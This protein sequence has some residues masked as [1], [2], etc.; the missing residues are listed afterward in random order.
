MSVCWKLSDFSGRNCPMNEIPKVTI[1]IPLRNGEDFIACT[2]ENIRLCDYPA[3]KLEVLIGNHDSTD[4]SLSIIREYEKNIP[5]KTIHVPYSGP[6][7]AYNRNQIIAQA[8]GEIIIFIDADIL[9]SRNFIIEH[10]KIHRQFDRAYVAGYTFGKNPITKKIINDSLCQRDIHSNYDRLHNNPHYRDYRVISKNAE[11]VNGIDILNP[12]DNP[13][14]LFW[15]CNIS[16]RTEDIK[17]IGNFDEN[18]T[19]WGLEDDELAYRCCFNQF[20]MIFSEKAWCFHMP[21]EINSKRNYIE[22]QV[23]LEYFSQKWRNRELEFF[24]YYGMPKEGQQKLNAD[25]DLYPDRKTYQ[26]IIEKA[27]VYLQDKPESRLAF[28]LFDEKSAE[29]LN[30][31]H[32]C[33]P[34]HDWKTLPYKKGNCMFYS[35]LGIRTHFDKGSIEETILLFDIILLIGNM[36]LTL[37]INECLRISKKLTVI[38]GEFSK[39]KIYQPQIE[40]FFQILNAVTGANDME[41]KVYQ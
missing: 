38:Y 9:I 4:K 6:N 1:G 32:C 28:Y 21:H 18:F 11:P 41:I 26:A 27:S 33:I 29:L 7:R 8:T 35:Y 17:Q 39:D 2:L 16:V 5:L 37:L 22:K 30:L 20:T 34:F 19:G 23:N 10:V 31:T 40:K 25:L 3:D 12:E 36:H 13:W 24:H 15:S 14:I